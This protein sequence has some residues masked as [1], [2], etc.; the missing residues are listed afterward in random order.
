LT[1]EI[2]SPLAVSNDVRP[3]GFGENHPPGKNLE[4][5]VDSRLVRPVVGE[6]FR[7]V[8]GPSEGLTS[9]TG[10]KRDTV[11]LGNFGGSLSV[12]GKALGTAFSSKDCSGDSASSIGVV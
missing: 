8:D 3:S 7:S 1:G 5:V 12:D 2:I 9:S 10:A 6:T 4:E 11:G